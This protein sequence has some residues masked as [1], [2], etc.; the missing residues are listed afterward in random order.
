MIQNDLTYA[1]S[2]PSSL[3]ILKLEKASDIPNQ[4]SALIQIGSWAYP[5]FTGQTTILKNELGIYVLPNPTN[6]MPGIFF[7]ACLNF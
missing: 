3:A 2:A 4:P 6:E 7:N 1:P 5:L